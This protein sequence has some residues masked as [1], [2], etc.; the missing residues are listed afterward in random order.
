MIGLTADGRT[1][2]RQHPG[3]DKLTKIRPH[4]GN[5]RSTG[6]P[7]VNLSLMPLM[8]APR[9]AIASAASFFAFFLC[10]FYL[11]GRAGYGIPLAQA[12]RWPLMLGTVL[13]AMDWIAQLGWLFAS[14]EGR[15]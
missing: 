7:I 13:F 15:P 8:G 9:A 3:R 4:G 6:E 10:Q 1:H 12:V 5:L 11:I 14:L 2:L